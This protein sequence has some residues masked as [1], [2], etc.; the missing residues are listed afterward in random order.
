MP[1][2]RSPLVATGQQIGAGWTPA[3]SVVKALAALVE[4]RRL[5]GRAVYWLADEDHD[6][7]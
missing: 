6:R 2:S 4:A 7:L 3:L 1:A 5:G